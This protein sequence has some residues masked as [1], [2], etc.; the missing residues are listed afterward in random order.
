MRTA[1]KSRRPTVASVAGESSPAATEQS[2]RRSQRGIARSAATSNAIPIPCPMPKCALPYPHQHPPGLQHYAGTDPNFQEP[3][4][5]KKKVARQAGQESPATK[6]VKENTKTGDAGTRKPRG[7]KDPQKSQSSDRDELP[8]PQEFFTG[9]NPNSSDSAFLP[10]TPPSYDTGAV[11]SGS[12]IASYTRTY[13]PYEPELPPS[14]SAPMPAQPEINFEEW[15]QFPDSESEDEEKDLYRAKASRKLNA[16]TAAARVIR[17]DLAEGTV[18]RM[19]KSKPEPEDG[20]LTEWSTAGRMRK[21]KPNSAVDD[22]MELS[23]PRRM[24]KSRPQ[25]GDDDYTEGMYEETSLTLERADKDFEELWEDEEF[26]EEWKAL[27]WMQ[28]GLLLVDW[29]F[30]VN[31]D[32]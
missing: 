10:P 17:D 15:L 28:D 18:G 7:R 25:P 4:K 14:S 31:S 19:R 21:G 20:D 12:Y 24:R 32:E 27:Q 9:N 26:E 29:S 22:L 23:P 5:G 16:S 30:G 3:T 6:P 13:E 11:S 8:L 1:H 2:P